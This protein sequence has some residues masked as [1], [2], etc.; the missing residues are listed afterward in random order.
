MG[1]GFLDF[2][3]GLDG[4]IKQDVKQ[5]KKRDYYEFLDDEKEVCLDEGELM[6]I[7]GGDGDN[8]SD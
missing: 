2:L 3:D 7:A 6:K 8:S 4:Q 1:V 5:Y